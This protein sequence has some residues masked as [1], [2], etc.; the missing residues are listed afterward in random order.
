MDYAPSAF[1]SKVRSRRP[2]VHHI[3]NYVTVNDCAN[4]CICAG[5]S[6]VMTDDIDDV[7]DM[8][9]IADCLVINIGTLNRRTIA[10]MLAAGE[11]ARDA[12]VPIV[13]DPV[14]VGATPLR[15]NTS[16]E[17]IRRLEPQVIKGNQGEMGVISG[18]GGDVRGVDS[19]GASG[20]IAEAVR[21]IA[22]EHGC[23][24]ASTGP[25]DHVSDGRSVI[26]LSN[27]APLL[28]AVSGTGCMVSSV[29]GCYVGANGAT[30][31]AVASAISAFNI[32]AE[33]AARA[34]GGPGTFKPA[35]LDA[36]Y[37]QDGASLDARV[38]RETL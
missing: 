36:V 25:V 11:A 3:T 14:G 13:L 5:G 7:C 19:N 27:G 15:T 28:E 30:V 37:N 21:T 31:D 16:M 4:V 9:R 18:L 34:A 24:A 29:I 22:D 35:L 1:L 38:R 33:D 8:V 20:D 10:S 23:I 26:R 32:S 12:R 6:P 2:L 17:L